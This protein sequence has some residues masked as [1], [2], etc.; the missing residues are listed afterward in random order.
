M[1]FGLEA[2]SAARAAVPIKRGTIVVTPSFISRVLE[3]IIGSK[4]FV[5][6]ETDLS[7]IS[8]FNVFQLCYKLFLNGVSYCGRAP[9]VGGL[10]D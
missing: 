2:A 4:K 10:E 7:L 6:Q 3:L 8:S 1:K 5:F 9:N